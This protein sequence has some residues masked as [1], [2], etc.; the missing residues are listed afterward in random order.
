MESW[1]VWDNVTLAGSNCNRAAAGAGSPFFSLRGVERSCGGE[2]SEW[3][4]ASL[5]YSASRNHLSTYPAARVVQSAATRIL[6]P[7][8]YPLLH[9]TPSS[10][11]RGLWPGEEGGNTGRGKSITKLVSSSH[12]QPPRGTG[13]TTS[14][15][16]I[17]DQTASYPTPVPSCIRRM[18][19]PLTASL[20][21]QDSSRQNNAACC[22]DHNQLL[23]LQSRC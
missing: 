8:R 19:L 18:F 3:S 23:R 12:L 20:P 2:D 5:Q 22:I 7:V 17:H 16:P 9:A 1:C 14:R 10:R 21:T 4:V 13:I 11:R 6:V 15:S